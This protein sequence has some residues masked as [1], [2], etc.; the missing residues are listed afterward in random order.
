M[1]KELL[2][3]GGPERSEFVVNYFRILFFCS[4]YLFAVNTARAQFD[5]DDATDAERLSHVYKD[6]NVIC[7]S[8]HRVFTFDKGLNSLND[9]VVTVQED[10]VL[11]FLSLKKYSSLTY[12]EF[13]NKF[14]R[15]KTFQKANKKGSKFITSDRSGVDRSLTDENIFFDDS[16]VQYYPIRFSEKG[17]VARITV[18]KEYTDAKY[19]PRLF[20]HLPYPV[21]EQIF[22]F[23]VPDWLS[24]DFKT[25]CFDGFKI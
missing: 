18:K 5:I 19:L 11:E 15:L 12:P 2:V 17:S 10:A 21:S 8:S 14:I 1:Q 16:R 22:E 9:K 7:R 3:P 24:V 20:F 4:I 6:D 23:K 25:Y 13:Y